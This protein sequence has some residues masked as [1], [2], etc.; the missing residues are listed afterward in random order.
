[1]GQRAY[2]HSLGAPKGAPDGFSGGVSTR[3]R[4]IISGL[5][6]VIL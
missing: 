5:D 1:M 4:G 3:F 6:D 2:L